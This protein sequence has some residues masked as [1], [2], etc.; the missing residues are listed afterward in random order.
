[1]KRFLTLSAV[2]A[3]MTA[4]SAMADTPRSDGWAFWGGQSLP[5]RELDTAYR[6]PVKGYDTRVYEW[7]PDGAPDWVCIVQFSKSGPAGMQCLPKSTTNPK[8]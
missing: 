5:E 2:A 4:A 1:M 8:D 3:A 7:T 6:L